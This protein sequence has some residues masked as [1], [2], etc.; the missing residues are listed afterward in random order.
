MEQRFLDPRVLASISN[1]ELVAKTVVDGFVAGLHRSPHFGFSQE[2]AEYRMYSEGDDLRFVDWNVFARTERAYIKRFK[3]ETN[4]RLTILIDASASMGYGSEEVKKIDYARFLAA[5][6]AYMANQQRDAA[7]VIVFDDEVREYVTASSRQGNFHRTLFAINRAEPAARTDF[8]KPFFHFQSTLRNRRG[9]V[10]VLSDFYEDPELIIKTI[11]PLRYR[12]NDVVL[13]H[14]LDPQELRPKFDGPV[15]LIDSETESELETSPEYAAQEYRAKI[16][17]H[18]SAL[19]T[20]AR[21]AGLSYHM[22]ATNTPL[23]AALREFLL[24]RQGRM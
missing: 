13:F 22:H 7:G 4:S 6:I 21:A 11:E 10:V 19:E 16:D 9:L 24:V 1:L 17:S 14:L 2:F 12:G 5:S 8:A 3:G 18:V 20:K 23:D 15:L